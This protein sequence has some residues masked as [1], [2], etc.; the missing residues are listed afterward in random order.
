MSLFVEPD[1][2]IMEAARDLGAPVVELHTGTCCD[3]V[4]EGD[5]AREAHEL[6]A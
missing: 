2:G 5:P 3:V 1:S 4:A 6:D